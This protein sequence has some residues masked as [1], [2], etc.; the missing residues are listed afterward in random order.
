MAPKATFVLS[1]SPFWPKSPLPCF[2]I[3]AQRI[4][5]SNG[6]LNLVLLNAL[7]KTSSFVYSKLMFT[8]ILFF[9]KLIKGGIRIKAEELEKFSRINDKRGGGQ[10]FGT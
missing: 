6:S 7:L 8:I 3:G 4:M 10:L 5:V 2:S 1:E 9:Q